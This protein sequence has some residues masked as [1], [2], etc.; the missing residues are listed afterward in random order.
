MSFNDLDAS[1]PV[2]FF[3]IGPEEIVGSVLSR[4]LVSREY[5]LLNGSGGS[6]DH[7]GLRCHDH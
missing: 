3:L 6:I 4:I 2:G 7:G 5:G 1:C